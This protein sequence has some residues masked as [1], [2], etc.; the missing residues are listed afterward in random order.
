MEGG[1]TD[2]LRKL[3]FALQRGRHS[4]LKCKLYE[5]RGFLVFIAIPC[6]AKDNEWNIADA[7]Y[8]LFP[9]ALVC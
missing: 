2:H 1:E 9:K 6:I 7:Q 8:K 5:Y 3:G 4:T